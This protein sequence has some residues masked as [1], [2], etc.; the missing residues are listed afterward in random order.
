MAVA[1]TS[2]AVVAATGAYA[3][4]SDSH[5][6]GQPAILFPVLAAAVAGA[7]IQRVS[8]AAWA[9]VI[10]GY[11][12]G[13]AIILRLAPQS[14]HAIVLLGA[15]GSLSSIP[16]VIVACLTAWLCQSSTPKQENAC[17]KCGYNLTGNVS[18]RCPECGTALAPS[19]PTENQD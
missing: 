19:C 16:C 13:A 3:C 7:V 4:A 10:A 5:G 11:A 8:I 18:G 2:L 9:G 1:L 17:Q 14:D 6:F 12:G 15:L